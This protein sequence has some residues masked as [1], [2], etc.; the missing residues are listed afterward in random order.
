MPDL[1]EEFFQFVFPLVGGYVISHTWWLSSP[2]PLHTA[3]ALVRG[4]GQV[5]PPRFQH[6][7][8]T[9]PKPKPL[10]R[11]NIKVRLEY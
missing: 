9:L 2:M 8:A 1:Q 3:R 10:T 11:Q 4:T 7:P 6:H 5:N